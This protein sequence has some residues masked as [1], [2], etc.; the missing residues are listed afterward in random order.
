[1]SEQF[2]I[3]EYGVEALPSEQVG[4][5]IRSR[6]VSANPLEQ[7]IL[8]LTDRRV[9]VCGKQRLLGFLPW[10][11]FVHAARIEDV[12]KASRET[13]RPH[14]L[15]PL[16]GV[17]LLIGGAGLIA[18]GASSDENEFG[19][20]NSDDATGAGIFALLAGG[21]IFA[22]VYLLRRQHLVFTVAGEPS[23]SV[24]VFQTG[25]EP[26]PAMQV[27]NA[28][29]ALKSGAQADELGPPIAYA[30]EAAPSAPRPSAP[31]PA[32][33]RR[34]GPFGGDR[35]GPEIGTDPRDSEP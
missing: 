21:A 30:P 9:V 19:Q 32:I 17:L 27:I 8:T 11:W 3:P 10:G 6:S 20:D 29:F 14:W 22:G 26:G 15:W 13:R 34:A 31:E 23:L 1:M 7:T 28:F 16:I 5:Q 2:L 12:D 25:G 24:R 18:D 33:R 35:G 4:R